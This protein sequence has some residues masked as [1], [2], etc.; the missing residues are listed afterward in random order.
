[1][2]YKLQ[3]DSYIFSVDHYSGEIAFDVS[4]SAGKVTA[5]EQDRGDNAVITYD[6]ISHLDFETEEDYR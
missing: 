5:T 4:K 6:L 3:R 1:M 2:T